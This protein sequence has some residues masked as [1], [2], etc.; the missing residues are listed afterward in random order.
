MYPVGSDLFYLS[1]MHLLVTLGLL[2][3]YFCKPPNKVVTLGN[4]IGEC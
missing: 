2:L 1:L 3:W 4:N